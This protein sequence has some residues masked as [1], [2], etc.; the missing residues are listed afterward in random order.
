MIFSLPALSK[1]KRVRSDIDF[2]TKGPLYTSERKLKGSFLYGWFLLN[3]KPYS[4]T[5]GI[6]STV[7]TAMAPKKKLPN[8]SPLKKITTDKNQASWVTTMKFYLWGP[9][10]VLWKSNQSILVVNS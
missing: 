6:N 3:K 9:N 8:S 2:A 7:K 4:Q 5:T 10:L 1:L